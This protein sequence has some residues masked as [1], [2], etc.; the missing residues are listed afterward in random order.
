MFFSRA[1]RRV[2]SAFRHVQCS[3]LVVKYPGQNRSLE[4]LLVSLYRVLTVQFLMGR[5]S[6]LKLF[7]DEMLI[8]SLDH[9]EVARVGSMRYDPESLLRLM[10]GSA[11]EVMVTGFPLLIY[12]YI[13][14]VSGDANLVLYQT[15]VQANNV[16]TVKEDSRNWNSTNQTF[17]KSLRKYGIC[18]GDQANYAVKSIHFKARKNPKHLQKK[19]GKYR[20]P[21]IM[22]GPEGLDYLAWMVINKTPLSTDRTVYSILDIKHWKQL[23]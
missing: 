9:D 10:P 20:I 19:F 17:Q 4:W 23:T 21:P 14:T 13:F 18:A 3:F 1:V 12:E 7:R 8:T 5:S 15:A 11:T 16:A 6:R 2:S 22:I